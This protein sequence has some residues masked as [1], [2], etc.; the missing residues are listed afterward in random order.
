M[1]RLGLLE[2]SAL[3]H[4]ALMVEPDCGTS[5]SGSGIST[6]DGGMNR[7]HWH[8]HVVMPMRYLPAF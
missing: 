7:A 8:T 5:E 4:V 6:R 2:L 1:P 3:R